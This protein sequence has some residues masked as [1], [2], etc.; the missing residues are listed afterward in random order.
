MLVGFVESLRK[1]ESYKDA[2]G[3]HASTDDADVDLDNGPISNR[4]V[5]IYHMLASDEVQAFSF[6]EK[7]MIVHVGF[8]VFLKCTRDCKRK[9]LTIVT[10]H[11]F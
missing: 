5:I 10:L 1:E 3:R 4:I 6:R 8:V 11:L 9:M 2:N 7:D